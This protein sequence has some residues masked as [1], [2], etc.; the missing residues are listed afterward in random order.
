M[1]ATVGMAVVA[2]VGMVVT[3]DMVAVRRVRNLRTR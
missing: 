3:V 2:T 1:A